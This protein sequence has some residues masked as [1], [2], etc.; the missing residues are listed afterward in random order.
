MVNGI[1]SADGFV[2]DMVGAREFDEWQI[3]NEHYEEVNG[4]FV[5]G[6]GGPTIMSIMMIYQ[7][8]EE[9]G[10]TDPVVIRDQLR[11]YNKDNCK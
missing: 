11:T 2:N 7:A 3:I 4:E 8:I 6:Q 9:T 5:P 10:S 1:I